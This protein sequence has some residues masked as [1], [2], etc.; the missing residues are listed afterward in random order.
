MTCIVGLSHEGNVYIG[1]DS[2]ASDGYSK[3]ATALR[4]VFRVGEFLIGYTSSFRMG[5][6]LQYHLEVRHQ[7]DGETDERYMVVAFIEGVRQCLKDKGYARIDS[8]E[9]RGG[10][11]LAGYRGRIYQID[12]DFQIN[13]WMSGIAACGAGQDYALGAMFALAD[14]PPID[15]IQKALAISAQLSSYVYEPFYVESLKPQI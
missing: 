5:Q 15:R 12:S 6:I 11:F 7:Q 14:L 2:M 3:Q 13:T 9:E 1:G 10:Q 8:N 4:K